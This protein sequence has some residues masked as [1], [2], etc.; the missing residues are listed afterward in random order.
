MIESYSFGEMKI[1]GV[2]YSSDLI[3]L[4]EMIGLKLG[5]HRGGRD[6]KKTDSAYTLFEVTPYAISHYIG[7][8]APTLK[9]VIHGNPGIGATR[10]S[11]FV[12]LK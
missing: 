3:V 12:P 1:N 8:F 9:R 6:P 5:V 11:M 7:E 2:T 10:S 4:P